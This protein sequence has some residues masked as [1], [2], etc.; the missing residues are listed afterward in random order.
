MQKKDAELLIDLFQP[1]DLLFGLEKE[2]RALFY[3]ELKSKLALMKA[4]H[5]YVTIDEIVK[6]MEPYYIYGD[7][8]RMSPLRE[9]S[10]PV[11]NHA[12]VLI[13]SPSFIEISTLPLSP[14]SKE[15]SKIMVSCFLAIEHYPGKI[16]FCLDGINFDKTRRNT[17]VNKNDYHSYTSNE[18][19]YIAIHYDTIKD[20]VQF[21]RNGCCVDPPWILEGMRPEQWLE[22]YYEDYTQLQP[23]AQN[24]VLAPKK[25]VFIDDEQH[26]GIDLSV[27]SEHKRIKVKSH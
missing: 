23:I 20:K 24:H 6:P 11:K 14:C 19:R 9:E 5:H 3:H 13:S 18:L 7:E 4:K 22:N 8:L 17:R 1:G 25:L 16:H 15:H 12:R 2:A 21:Y 26:E 27:E 10:S